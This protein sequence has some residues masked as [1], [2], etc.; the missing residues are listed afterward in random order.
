MISSLEGLK[1]GFRE[2]TVPDVIASNRRGWKK[3]KRG[4][5]NRGGFD[6]GVGRELP[7]LHLI[8]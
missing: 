8:V 7:F 5:K 2:A 1:G 3:E 4:D 6:K